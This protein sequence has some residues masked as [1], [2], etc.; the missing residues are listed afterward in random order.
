MHITKL[1]N[2]TSQF[3][4]DIYVDKYHDFFTLKYHDIDHDIYR[5]HI[6]LIFSYNPNPTVTVTLTLKLTLSL[7][8]FYKR[9]VQNTL[10]KKNFQKTQNN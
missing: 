7:K 1:F 6:S 4:F 8:L 9:N 2:Y 10:R 3:S 5:W